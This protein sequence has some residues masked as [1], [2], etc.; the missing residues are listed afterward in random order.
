LVAGA[1]D[2]LVKPFSARELV[3]RVNAH[4]E[5]ARV[6]QDALDREQA[7]RT[8]AEQANRAKDEFLL[9]LSHELRTPLN[10][11]LG[12]SVMLKN[13]HADHPAAVSR[14]L[15]V[16]ERNARIQAHL[17]EDLLDVSRI[18]SGKLRLDVRPMDL[19]GAIHAALDAARPAAAAKEIRLQ[20]ILDPKA[21]LVSGDPERLQ[22]VFSNLLSNAVKF[23]P[24]GG[25]VQVR[26]E[27][28]NSHIE[29]VVS[30]NGSGIAPD[31]LPYIF[32]RFRQADSS[33]TRRHGG[34]GLGLAR[35]KPGGA[36]WR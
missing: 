17:I 3:A 9:V 33:T 4:L 13:D 24:K 1:D 20:P 6:R 35:Q 14:G 7:A 32:D 11:I 2:Y 8:I 31:L 25:R 18:V 27:R 34:L 12:W 10:A 22:Q 28:V 16:I 15:E 21:G 30:D 19:T 26:L 23:T 29:I 5:L 36:A